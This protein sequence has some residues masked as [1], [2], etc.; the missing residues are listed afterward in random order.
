M[1]ML[2]KELIVKIGYPQ[3]TNHSRAYI[4]S[5]LDSYIQNNVDLV[6][7]KHRWW[8]DEI[9]SAGGIIIDPLIS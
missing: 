9:I 7:G 5:Q 4:N 1:N 8:A 3:W 2:L 6:L